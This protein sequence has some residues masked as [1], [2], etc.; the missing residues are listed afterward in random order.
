MT[1]PP[2][3]TGKNRA[4]VLVLLTILALQVI[5]FA[6]IFVPVSG[7]KSTYVPCRFDRAGNSISTDG[8]EEFLVRDGQLYLRLNT[9]T[10]SLFIPYVQSAN[11]NHPA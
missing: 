10:Y 8:E 7:P 2:P 11:W 5:G 4:C 6:V 9:L 1:Q 3:P